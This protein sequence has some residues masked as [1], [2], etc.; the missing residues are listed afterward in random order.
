MDLA[1]NR[2][3]QAARAQA[4]LELAAMKDRTRVGTFL[5]R[6]VDAK[7]DERAWRVGADGEETVGARLEKLTAQGWHVLHAVP[8]GTKGS[9]I[10]HVLI[11]PG[12]VY[13]LNTKHHPGGKVWVGQ[14]AIKVN[15]HSVQY[16]RNSRF[17]AERASKLLT[18]AVGWPVFVKPVLIFLTG[19]L[20]PDVTIKQQPD[21]VVVLDRP[22]GLQACPGAH[23]GPAGRGDVLLGSSVSDVGR[24]SVSASQLGGRHLPYGMEYRER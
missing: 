17:E 2:P 9:D 19:T 18:A 23:D 10:D 14:H 1:A 24:A 7:T 11:G 5:A 3:G 21:D 16:L 8:V 12:G 13:T 4:V 6:L 15:G 20:I 22:Q